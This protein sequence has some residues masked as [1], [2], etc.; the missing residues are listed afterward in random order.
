[1]C[2]LFAGIGCA[3]VLSAMAC[4]SGK[5]A[6]QR[7]NRASTP[8]VSSTDSLAWGPTDPAGDSAFAL[9]RLHTIDTLRQSNIYSIPGR[10]PRFLGVT[11]TPVGH[12][13]AELRVFLIGRRA[14]SWVVLDSTR[15]FGDAEW[16]T[17]TF[18]GQGPEAMAL[19]DYGSEYSWGTLAFELGRDTLG[20]LRLPAVG[21]P[22]TDDVVGESASAL[23][24]L[25]VSGTVGR[26]VVSADGDLIVDPG[27][28]EQHFLCRD[29]TSV[30]LR[31]V[32]SDSGWSIANASGR[33]ACR[34]GDLKPSPP[35]PPAP[36]ARIPAPSPSAGR[37]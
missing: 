2:R 25:T 9:L 11:W 10:P 12:G 37:A 4:G 8:T 5:P 27:R 29:S 13:A 31:I 21:W 1:M 22:V 36:A 18:W 23:S 30:S 34:G 19:F 24:H 32:Q 20:D 26:R 33:P 6:S 16:L 3:V 17:P 14:D 7:E 15:G 28:A 35:P